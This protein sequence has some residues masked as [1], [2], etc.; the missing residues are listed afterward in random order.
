MKNLKI[1]ILAALTCIILFLMYDYH[2]RS[3]QTEFLLVGGITLDALDRSRLMRALKK[4]SE[5]DTITITVRSTGGYVLGL[6][7]LISS[8]EDT[9]AYVIVKV[10]AYAMSAAAVLTCHA[11]KVIYSKYS[12]AM[13]HLPRTYNLLGKPVV[14]TDSSDPT[15]KYFDRMFAK[16]KRF[17][18]EEQLAAY[19]KGFDVYITPEQ[20]NLFNFK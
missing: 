9:L 7:P 8:L 1:S 19:Y 10:D 11:D 16:C 5:G 14:M 20:M 12:V 4:A 15:Y 17:M 18:N 2:S 13:F 6:A 3:N